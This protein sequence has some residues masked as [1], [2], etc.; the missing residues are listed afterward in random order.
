M[1]PG[2]CAIQQITPSDFA[3]DLFSNRPT[4]PSFPIAASLDL[5]SGCNLKCLH[6]FLRY[7]GVNLRNKSTRDVQALLKTLEELGVLFL[8]LTGGEPLSRPDF[9][10]IYRSAKRRGFFLM[11]FSNGTLMTDAIM[12]LLA[13]QPPRRIELTAYGHTEETYEAVTGIPGSFG[14]FRYAVDG[15]LRRGLLVRLKSMVLRT[16]VHEWEAIRNWAVTLGCDFQYDAI[17]HPCMNG[18]SRPLRERLSP[19]E[20]AR[21]RHSDRDRTEPAPANVQGAR[22][23]LFGCGAGLL[24][25]H[26]DAEHQAHP[27]MNWRIDP[28][29]MT[30][31]DVR[32]RWGAYLNALRDRPAPGG[33][34]DTCKD[35][36]QCQACVA[37]CLLETGQASGTPSFFCRLVRAEQALA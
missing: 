24:T 10:E 30:R 31:P 33:R 4:S 19:E 35:R 2:D 27:C 37:H 28:F 14:R 16:N 29:D 7:E 32:D 11:L 13:D 12:D 1:A 34:C 25:V 22:R 5:T 3:V 23:Y 6:C 9:S 17:I 18:D 21:F 36:G 15:L 20:I 8:V 26:I